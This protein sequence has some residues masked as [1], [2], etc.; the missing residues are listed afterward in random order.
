M[1]G[2]APANRARADATSTVPIS[3]LLRELLRTANGFAVDYDATG[4]DGAAVDLILHEL[5]ELTPTPL[6]VSLPHDEPF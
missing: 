6:S 3:P 2:T 5:R 4:R 1:T